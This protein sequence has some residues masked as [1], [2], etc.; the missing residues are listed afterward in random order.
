MI[1]SGL[2]PSLSLGEQL[3]RETQLS[4]LLPLPAVSDASHDGRVFRRSAVCSGSSGEPVGAAC[5]RHVSF[6]SVPSQILHLGDSDHQIRCVVKS[7]IFQL[8]I[9]FVCFWPWDAFFSSRLDYCNALSLGVSLSLISK[10]PKSCI[11]FR[12]NIGFSIR[13]C[14]MFLKLSMIYS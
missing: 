12:L 10:L 5:G 14:C 8:R 1:S 11:R 2:W 4:L 9:C 3:H 6:S 13:C 7:C